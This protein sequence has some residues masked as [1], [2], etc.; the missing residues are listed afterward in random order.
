MHCVL[1]LPQQGRELPPAR[2]LR[3][4]G[5][6]ISAAVEVEGQAEEPGPEPGALPLVQG[7]DDHG[8]LDG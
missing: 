7:P 3:C 1:I 4:W 6:S 5:F 8:C 2:L